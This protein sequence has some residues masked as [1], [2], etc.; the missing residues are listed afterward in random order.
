MKSSSVHEMK[1]YIIAYLLASKDR[2]SVKVA[3]MGLNVLLSKSMPICYE[4]DEGI[5]MEKG[6]CCRYFNS[7]ANANISLFEGPKKL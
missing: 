5:K 3:K 1:D 4:Y 7:K 2:Q 6:Q